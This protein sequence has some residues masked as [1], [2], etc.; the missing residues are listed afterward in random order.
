M[1]NT[2][3][4]YHYLFDAKYTIFRTQCFQSLEIEAWMCYANQFSAKNN[5]GQLQNGC[6]ERGYYITV[7]NTKA[8]QLLTQHRQQLS[9]W[10]LKN[11]ASIKLIHFFTHR[12]KMT[13]VHIVQIHERKFPFCLW[14]CKPVQSLICSYS[15]DTMQAITL[16]K[17]FA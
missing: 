14:K 10:M 2:N 8:S 17:Q 16:T 1:Y 6:L 15:H 5:C 11:H 9:L 3:N 13:L 4:F 7:K 12:I